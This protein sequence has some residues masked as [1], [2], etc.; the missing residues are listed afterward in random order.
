MTRISRAREHQGVLTKP[1]GSLGRLEELAVLL[2]GQQ[3]TDTPKVDQVQISIFAADHGVCTEGISAF[4]QQVT[5]QMVANFAHGGAAISV[6][7][8]H[9]GASL[10]VIN[11]GTVEP[12]PDLPGVLTNRI[13]PGTANLA[14]Q[15]AMTEAEVRQA[16]E[17]GHQVS[18]RAADTGAQ[19]F[20]GGD[21]GIGN[22]TSAA[23]VACVLLGEAP[24]VIVGPGTGLDVTG[25]RHKTA[26][27]AQALRRHGDDVTPLSV[28]TSLG[29]FEIAAL[30][31]AMLG[32][33]HRRIPILVD[34]FIVSVA[35]LV[36]VLQQPGLADWLHFSHRSGEPGHSRILAAL[37]ARPLL[38]L[39]MRLGE[40]S[41]AAIALP[42]LRQAC[43]LHNE[44]ASFDDAGVD[45]GSS[46]E[47]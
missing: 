13:G 21:M 27:V 33:A 39:N 20:I 1:P 9:L 22:T 10:E 17:A 26:V 23:A 29:G 36:G 12:L 34:G 40:A 31:G 2:C 19:L 41:G 16:L 46:D 25:V 44:M 11:L 42:L 14:L 45:S 15:S 30:T 6:L 7:A 8:R 37:M 38:D 32:C 5:G 28:L 35:A 43:A 4:P 24:S 18:Q 47:P 3:D